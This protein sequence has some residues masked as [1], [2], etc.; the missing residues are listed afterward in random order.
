MS[1][2]DLRARDDLIV[3]CFNDRLHERRSEYL[4]LVLICCQ[5]SL[6]FEFQATEMLNPWLYLGFDFYIFQLNCII[7]KFQ[8]IKLPSTQDSQRLPKDASILEPK[9]GT[10]SL[11]LVV[12]KA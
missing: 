11:F 5:S 3:E 4:Y 7:F 12:Y 6:G 9:I 1:G 10:F 8:E 2:V